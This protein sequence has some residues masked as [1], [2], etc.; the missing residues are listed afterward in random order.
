[1]N[2]IQR[3]VRKYIYLQISRRRL[4]L[5]LKYF[6]RTAMAKVGRNDPCPCGSGKKYKKCCQD[7]ESSETEQGISGNVGEFKKQKPHRYGKTHN[8]PAKHSPVSKSKVFRR[9]PTSSGK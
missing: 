9:P 6:V 5:F 4:H 8:R 3:I 2:F 1:M 7:K